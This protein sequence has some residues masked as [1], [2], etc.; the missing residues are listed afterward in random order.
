MK[1]E[2]MDLMSLFRPPTLRVKTQ[3]PGR[4][5]NSQ[6]FDSHSV[7]EVNYSPSS[8]RSINPTIQFRSQQRNTNQCS[9]HMH[10]TQPTYHSTP[11]LSRILDGIPVPSTLSVEMM[12]RCEALTVCFQ[13]FTSL[14]LV[15]LCELSEHNFTIFQ[16]CPRNAE[17]AKTTRKMVS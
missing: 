16:S 4:Y 1:Q 14:L 11:N 6:E 2:S 7:V 8:S 9:S 5:G 17:N 12:H 10:V 13:Q 3:T 15:E